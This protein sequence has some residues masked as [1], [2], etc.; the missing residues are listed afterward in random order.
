MNPTTCLC[1]ACNSAVQLLKGRTTRGVNIPHIF[2]H[3]GKF[4]EIPEQNCISKY[5]NAI[6]IPGFGF[7]LPILLP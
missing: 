4:I 6:A 1:V 3:H 7:F 5:E 2:Y